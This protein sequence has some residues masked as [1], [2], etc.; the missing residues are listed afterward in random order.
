M[1]EKTSFWKYFNRNLITQFTPFMFFSLLLSVLCLIS[2]RSY[3]LQQLKSKTYDKKFLVEQVLNDI[4]TT[5]FSLIN[6]FNVIALMLSDNISS[7]NTEFVNNLEK[8]QELIYTYLAISD[9]IDSIYILNQN[10]QMIYSNYQNESI[11]R[12]FDKQ[13]V[14]KYKHNSYNPYI[15]EYSKASDTQQQADYL[16]FVYNYNLYNK[17]IGVIAININAKKLKESLISDEDFSF[18]L[19]DDK[20]SVLLNTA[21]EYTLTDKELDFALHGATEFRSHLAM[22]NSISVYSFPQTCLRLVMKA[23]NSHTAN[24]FFIFSISLVLYTLLIFCLIYVLSKR[25]ACQYYKNISNV[26]DILPKFDAESDMLHKS[27]EFSYIKK[28]ISLLLNTIN[29]NEI[30]LAHKIIQLKHSQFNAL[31]TQISPHFIANALNIVNLILIRSDDIHND[32]INVNAK[33]AK[34]LS[35]TLATHEYII[36]VSKEINCTNDFLDIE[37]LSKNNSF[38]T[39]WDVDNACLNLNTI[40]FILQPIV[41]NAIEHGLAK[42]TKH[43]KLLKIS[44]KKVNNQIIFTVADNGVGMTAEKLAEINE[45]LK[46]NE[47][48]IEKNIAMLNVHQR[49]QLIFG[50]EYGCSILKSDSDG[51]IIQ[52][53]TPADYI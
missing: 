51:T 25:Y 5:H 2:V 13:W 41:E 16:S 44:I 8:T 32:A 45:A 17:T 3:T 24:L 7:Q 18:I 35:N 11:D 19:T 29:D 39:K 46:S 9:N 33:I 36:P 52:L 28:N 1:K 50:S 14:S 26:I 6:N 23:N 22:N 37:Y 43:N 53:I 48:P 31:Q 21:I 4:N 34:I 42:S 47:F 20:G 15:F 38:T 12:F 27:D 40:K 30:Q 10:T 49:I